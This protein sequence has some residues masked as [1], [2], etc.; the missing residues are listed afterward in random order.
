MKVD[1]DFYNLANMQIKKN[2]K[3]ENLKG[4]FDFTERKQTFTTIE[5]LLI[6]KIRQL[7]VILLFFYL[8]SMN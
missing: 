1:N 7:N 4:R 5:R 6:G 2:K 8:V 3:E